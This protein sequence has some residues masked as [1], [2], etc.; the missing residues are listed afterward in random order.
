MYRENMTILIL[1]ASVTVQIKI[2]DLLQELDSENLDI[3]CF[4]DGSEALEY[5]KE[6]EVDLVFSAIETVGLDGISF[7]DIL[8]RD[9]PKLVSKLFIVTSQQKNEQVEDI[10]GVG[11]KRF[12]RKPINEEYFKHFVLPE[13]NKILK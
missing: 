1:D 3:K 9:K 8:L 13:I 12:I 7:V 2:R 4:E 5:V 10:K 11:A 6:N